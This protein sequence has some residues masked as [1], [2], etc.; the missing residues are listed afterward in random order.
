VSGTGLL[1][2]VSTIYL[3][4][5]CSAPGQKNQEYGRADPLHWPRDTLYPQ[6]L[7]LTWLT[8]D[9]RSV[10]IVRSWTKATEL[11]LVFSF[12]LRKCNFTVCSIFSIFLRPK[13][14]HPWLMSHYSYLRILYTIGHHYHKMDKGHVTQ[15]GMQEIIPIT[16]VAQCNGTVYTDVGMSETEFSGTT[17]LSLALQKCSVASSKWYCTTN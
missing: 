8:G 15:W 4:E 10:S 5:I 12:Q 17:F 6:K 13:N 9:D 11:S 1:S 14:L 7:A 2:L 3:E 16:W